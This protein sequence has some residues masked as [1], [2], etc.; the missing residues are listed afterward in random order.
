MAVRVIIVRPARRANNATSPGNYEATLQGETR[1]FVRSSTTP[2][3]D[4]AR[5]LLERGS[6]ADDMLIMRWHDAD[7]V[8][9]LKARL[10][11]AARFTVQERNGTSPSIRLAPYA[12]LP[13]K[14]FA[15]PMGGSEKS[16]LPPRGKKGAA[17]RPA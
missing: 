9:S 4:A 14:I 13:K 6:S 1:A 2:F 16:V 8:D 3:L 12:P 5:A 15:Q 17:A 11:V 10:G 7:G